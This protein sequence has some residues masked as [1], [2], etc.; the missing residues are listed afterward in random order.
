MR[1][2]R[3]ILAA[4]SY[5]LLVATRDPSL[6]AEITSSDLKDGSSLI[7][8]SGDLQLG[9]E[10]KFIDVALGKSNAVVLLASTGGNLVAGIEIGRAI[11]LKGFSAYVPD[12][13]ICAS[14]C[15]LA[16]LGASKRALGR[17]SKIGFHA[18]S[19][20]QTGEVTATGN[21]LVGA[22]LS[23]LG[24]P[25]SAIV[26]ITETPP[27]DIRWM[28]LEEAKGHGIEA[29]LVELTPKTSASSQATQPA[30]PTDPAANRATAFIYDYHKQSSKDARAVLAYYSRVYAPEVNY[31]GKKVRLGSLLTDKASFFK[32]WP[33]RSYTVEPDSLSVSCNDGTCSIIG[34]VSWDMSAPERNAKSV[35]TASYVVTLDMTS[36]QPKITNE[37]STVVTRN[38]QAMI[39]TEQPQGNYLFNVLQSQPAYRASWDTMM[40]TSSRLPGWVYEFSRTYNG[41]ATPMRRIRHKGYT[42]EAF[43]VCQPHDCAGHEVVVFF[44]PGGSSAWGIIT[45]G[46]SVSWLGQKVPALADPLL[47]TLND[48]SYTGDGS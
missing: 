24:L 16:W 27:G 17:D 39:N 6:A 8:V 2:N 26:Y 1:T 38:L 36:A 43:Q 25:A 13:K 18:A 33:I 41:V 30:V 21:A 46:K 11:R 20:A 5:S 48:S 35:G 23:Q 42:F 28:T 7:F 3:V 32:R 29:T 44:T 12:E 4:F 9:D 10:K 31:Y 45:E 22:Y 34:M 47:K 15:A 37:W 19:V 14:A 40:A